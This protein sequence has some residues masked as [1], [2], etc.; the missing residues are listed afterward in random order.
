[1]HTLAFSPSERT[2]PAYASSP[3]GSHTASQVRQT[4]SGVLPSSAIR[5]RCFSRS[6]PPGFQKKPIGSPIDYRRGQR[7]RRNGDGN[8]HIW[9]H[10]NAALGARLPRL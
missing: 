8:A 5:L 3:G 10:Q 4:E 1:M 7:R 6:I 9:P 2:E